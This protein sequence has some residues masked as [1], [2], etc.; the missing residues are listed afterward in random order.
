M[1]DALGLLWLV[2]MFPLAGAIVALVLRPSKRL[3]SWL[4][5]GVILLAFLWSAAAVIQLAGLPSRTFE[6]AAGIWLPNIGAQWGLYLDPLSAIMILTVTGI[7]FLVHVYS[8]GYMAA[9]EGYVR[10]FGY[11]NLFVFFM[12]LLVLANNYGLLFAG[13]EGVGLASYLLVGFDYRRKGAAG[14]GMKAF[15]VNRTGDAGLLLGLLLLWSFTGSVRFADANAALAGTQSGSGTITAIAIL[16]FIGSTGK[17]AQFPLHVWLPDA[18]EGPAPVSALIHAATMVTAGVYLLARAHV[19]FD[20]SPQASTVIA[21]IGAFTAIF[22]ATIALVQTDIK[23]ILAYSTVSQLG[24]MFLALGTGA[25]WVAVFHLFTHAFFKALLF[26]GAGSVIHALH[27]EQDVRKMGALKRK[28]PI[29]H[30]TMFI[31]AVALSGIPGLAGFFSKDAI[32]AQAFYSGA[33]LLYSIGLVTAGLTAFYMWRLMHLTFY[34][35]SHV[36]A[37]H[38]HESPPA[39]TVPLIVLAAGSLLAGWIGV[40]KH[41]NTPALFRSFE[42]WLHPESS[43]ASPGAS[44]EWILTGLSVA[45]VLIGISIARYFYGHR[46]GVPQTFQQLA[47]PLQGVL[48]EEWYVDRIYTAFFVRGFGRGGGRVLNRFDGVIDR[49]V[50][51]TGALTRAA[52]AFSGW[53]DE[54]VIDGAVRVF[55]Y[56][57]KLLS[58]PARLLQ[59]GKLQTYALFVV[60]GLIAF[61]GYS[62][63]YSVCY[64]AWPG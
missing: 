44:M 61:L 10:Y 5:P 57:V 38:V 52:G 12:L 24:Y 32:L 13:W 53:W 49:G 6:A 62:V 37:A 54:W 23:R 27:G 4:A 35:E 17:S 7:S 56:S 64:F 42:L 11:L 51:L 9:D 18:M 2:P 33:T 55:A 58:Y 8:V 25:W 21:A 22:A 16:F 41:W 29:T 46:G 31:G 20:L 59:T 26:L 15:V 43:R 14:A 47:R 60:M 39:F 1:V 40:P 34:G 28:M 50:N 63:F 19:L 48:E 36:E 3:T 30:W 45:V